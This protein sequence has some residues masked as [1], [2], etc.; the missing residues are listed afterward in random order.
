MEKLK[1]EEAKQFLKKVQ[2]ERKSW[3]NKKQKFA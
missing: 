2:S 3:L 1:E